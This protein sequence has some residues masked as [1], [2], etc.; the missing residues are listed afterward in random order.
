M[1]D[2][3]EQQFREAQ[4]RQEAKVAAR[5][6]EA[7]RLRSA[8]QMKGLLIRDLHQLYLLNCESRNAFTAQEQVEAQRQLNEAGPP[9]LANIARLLIQAR[10]PL[11]MNDFDPAAWRAVLRQR[12]TPFAEETGDLPIDDATDLAAMAWRDQCPAEAIVARLQKTVDE[13]CRANT[14]EWLRRLV[15][16]A[17]RPREEPARDTDD[18]REGDPWIP[19]RR[20]DWE[21]GRAKFRYRD[22]WHNDFPAK[23]LALLEQFIERGGELTHQ[24]IAVAVDGEEEH[25]YR[26]VCNLRAALSK[27]FP[28]CGNL[29]RPVHGQRVYRLSSPR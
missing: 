19:P 11:G 4:E 1:S 10:E 9:L 7:E 20:R 28:G 14:R 3:F 2:P 23:A 24:Q 15:E 26:Y 29:I 8:S 6:E 21:F 17:G 5:Y 12:H 27:S 16:D 25:V 22:S 13:P 18:Q